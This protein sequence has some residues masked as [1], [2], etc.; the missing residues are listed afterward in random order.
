VATIREYFDTDARALT[1]HGNWTFGTSAGVPLAEVIAKIAYDFE[2]NAKYWYFYVP[3]MADLSQCLG[4]L[5]ASTDLENCR[6]GP[7]GDGVYVE[8]GT[9]S[10]PNGNPQRHCGLQGE[11]TSI[12][13]ST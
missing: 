11:S 8:T 7:D 6:L 13:T 1:L 12:S 2:A 10:I 5:F 3:A 4:A 9:P